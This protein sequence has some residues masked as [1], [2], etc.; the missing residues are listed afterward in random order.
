[1]ALSAKEAHK[2]LT[3]NMVSDWE[4][5]KEEEPESCSPLTSVTS[6]VRTPAEIDI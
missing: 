3:E 2:E 6:T 1:M 4:E 5:I